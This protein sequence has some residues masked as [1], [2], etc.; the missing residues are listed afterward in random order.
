MGFLI[1]IAYRIVLLEGN[2]FNIAIYFY[3]VYSLGLSTGRLVP[4][5][6]NIIFI[7]IFS[8][9]L[10]IKLKIGNKVI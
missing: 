1:M 6:I 9:I 5:I 4:V 3:I 10:R 7:S 8:K 2:S